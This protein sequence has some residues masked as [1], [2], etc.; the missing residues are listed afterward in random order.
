M[1]NVSPSPSF[2]QTILSY[3]TEVRV[4]ETQSEYHSILAV[5]LRQGRYQL[6]CEK[7]IYSF[8][9]KYDNF[10]LTFEQLKFRNDWNRVLV[11]GLGLASVPYMLEKIFRKSY[12][13]TA[14]ELDE[15]VAQLAQKYTMSR[16]DSSLEIIIADAINF[17]E[18]DE[19]CYD[20][21]IMDIFAEDIIPNK[22][23]TKE[24]LQLLE[25][26][27]NTNGVLLY[28][29]MGLTEFDIKTGKKFEAT[30]SAVFPNS[31]YLEV[32]DNWMFVHDQ[33]HLDN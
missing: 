25:S 18:I 28:N 6:C 31:T 9:D 13:Y 10:K 26:K 3:I 15:V 12:T 16:M 20:M 7:A 5:N 29:R 23:E 8:D 14:V 33:S 17:I 4:E 21:I 27:L 2:W 24:F 1:G 30:F 32:K 11:L 19:Q 22:F